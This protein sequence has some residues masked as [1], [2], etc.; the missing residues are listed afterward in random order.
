MVWWLLRVVAVVTLVAMSKG[1]IYSCGEVS[2]IVL[3]RRLLS[4]C[5][6]G[7]SLVLWMPKSLVVVGVSSCC[8]GQGFERVIF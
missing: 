1:L 3:S 4:C 2:N 5:S 6:G 8:I 7:I